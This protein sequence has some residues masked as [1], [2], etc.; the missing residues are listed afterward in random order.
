M[1]ITVIVGLRASTP[2]PMGRIT[3][4]GTFPVLSGFLPKGRSLSPVMPK[5]KETISLSPDWPVIRPSRPSGGV[6]IHFKTGLEQAANKD[7]MKNAVKS[8][9]I[10]NSLF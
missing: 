2:V 6:S 7:A 1:P 3:E 10:C 5:V 8:F 4:M 9:F